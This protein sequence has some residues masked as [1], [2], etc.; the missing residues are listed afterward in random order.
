MQVESLTKALNEAGTAKEMA[1]HHAAEI[2]AE[3][4]SLKRHA[5][6]I[7]EQLA[8]TMAGRAAGTLSG[9]G[10]VIAEERHARAAT[11]AAV[12]ASQQQAGSQQQP[13]ATY[14]WQPQAMSAAA[15]ASVTRRQIPRQWDATAAMPMPVDG[16]L[17]PPAR[18][19]HPSTGGRPMPPP[20]A[21]VADVHMTAGA[22]H[23]SWDD[24][25]EAELP[26]H[27]MSLGGYIRSLDHA[28]SA[29]Q[30]RAASQKARTRKAP[31]GEFTDFEATNHP[32]AVFARWDGTDGDEDSEDVMGVPS[33]QHRRGGGGGG[34]GNVKPTNAW[35]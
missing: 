15:E 31:E 12:A 30:Q 1:L 28:S 2:D 7:S 11:A 21:A 5:A 35:R 19:A 17:Q 9:I 29:Q 34:A 14:E 24:R 27:E 6:Q 25:A 3:L 32:E 18:A 16:N 33:Q 13:P 8:T 26:E 4:Q 10:T 22:P 20:A 23:P